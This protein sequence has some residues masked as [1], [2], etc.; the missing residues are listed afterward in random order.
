MRNAFIRDDQ[1]VVLIDVIHNLGGPCMD[2]TSFRGTLHR[3]L[4]HVA[5]FELATPDAL[6]TF[7]VVLWAQY[8]TAS[9]LGDAALPR[10]S[11]KLE[12]A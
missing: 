4:E 12:C 2:E 11:S 9:G 6:E 8:R 5:G 10:P 7:V 3:L 1:A